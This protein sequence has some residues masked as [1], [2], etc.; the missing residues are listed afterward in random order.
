MS[1]ILMMVALLVCQTNAS[2]TM[3]LD[4]ALPLLRQQA[5]KPDGQPLRPPV[6][7]VIVGQS[8]KGK[9]GQDGLVVD[10]QFVIDVLADKRWV[11]LPL[12]TLGPDVVLDLPDAPPGATIAP[13]D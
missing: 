1:S 13:K 10:A 4:E 6:D 2:V 9:P 5:D 8:L 3:P 11:Q 12:L 7:A